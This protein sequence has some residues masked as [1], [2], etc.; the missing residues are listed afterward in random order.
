MQCASYSEVPCNVSND[1]FPRLDCHGP[2]K[3][4]HSLIHAGIYRLFYFKER[5]NI[6]TLLSIRNLVPDILLGYPADFIWRRD[7]YVNHENQVCQ[8]LCQILIF[9]TR[10]T[11]ILIFFLCI[12]LS[13]YDSYY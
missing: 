7:F 6:R 5:L 8:I 12:L 9:V 3:Y 13:L 1:G 10:V 2:G 11:L 4:C